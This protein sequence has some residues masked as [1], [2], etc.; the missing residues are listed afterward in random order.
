MIIMGIDP[1]TIRAGYGVIKAEGSRI[2][3]LAY[4]VAKGGSD[5][6]KLYSTRLKN[7][8]TGLKQVIDKHQPELIVLVVVSTDH[9]VGIL[10]S[11]FLE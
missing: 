1:G 4:G 7:I 2:K 5:K 3:P 6:R 11:R 10:D 9:F 8:Y